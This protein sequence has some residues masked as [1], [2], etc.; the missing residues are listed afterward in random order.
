M[1]R[2]RLEETMR[3]SLSAKSNHG[4]RCRRSTYSINER[5]RQK[6]PGLEKGYAAGSARPFEERKKLLA[7]CGLLENHREVDYLRC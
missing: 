6:T 1:S 2:G 3:R 4:H 5:V 7:S